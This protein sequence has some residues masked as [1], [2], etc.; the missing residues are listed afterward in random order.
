MFS[1]SYFSILF[2]NL[3]D[4]FVKCFF[5][6]KKA[7]IHKQLILSNIVIKKIGDESKRSTPYKN[8]FLIVTH[9]NMLF[10]K[11]QLFFLLNL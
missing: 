4:C 8:K 6:N 2:Y 1:L 10:L 7:A 9:T 3:F 5:E 11:C